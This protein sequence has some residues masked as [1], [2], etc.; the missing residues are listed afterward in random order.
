MLLRNRIARGIAAGALVLALPTLAACG[1]FATDK[2]YTPAPGAN[3]R[4]GDV[5][6]LNAVIVAT[7]DGHGTFLATFSN[8]LDSDVANEFA[9]VSDELVSIEGDFTATMPGSDS[10]TE[11]TDAPEGTDGANA[12]Q[13]A[14][15][16]A[17]NAAATEPV[18][19]PAGS[20][21]VLGA[22][23]DA[24][25]IPVD[26]DFAI[27]DF[28]DVTLTFANAG[29][30]VVTVPVVCNANHWADQDVNPANADAELAPQCETLEG[31]EPAEGGH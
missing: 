19:V 11:A 13:A 22:Q 23:G 27:G 29:K 28:V 15:T 9:D 30:V 7:Q 18:V 14:D 21:F 1:D 25:G 16:D 2:V 20:A 24:P 3:D 10:A 26:G 31:G 17:S 12:E 4:A 5:D 6:V 8:N